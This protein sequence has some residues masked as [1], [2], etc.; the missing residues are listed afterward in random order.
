MDGASSSRLSIG[1]TTMH[2][3]AK[4]ISGEHRLESS[5]GQ[6]SWRLE[7]RD[8]ASFC[9]GLGLRYTV[10]RGASRKIARASVWTRNHAQ[11]IESR[12]IV[13]RHE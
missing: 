11:M 10:V 7:M 8:E 6:S 3:R 4:E 9:M 5:T 12:T 2:I 1:E 13:R